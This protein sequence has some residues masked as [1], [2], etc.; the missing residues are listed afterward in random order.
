MPSPAFACPNCD[1]IVLRAGCI[2]QL[3]VHPQFI[4]LWGPWKLW[5]Q[6]NGS[7]G[8]IDWEALCMNFEN[9]RRIVPEAMRRL[10]GILRASAHYPP[11]RSTRLSAR[12][13]HPGRRSRA[14]PLPWIAWSQAP[15][16]RAPTPAARSCSTAPPQR[17]GKRQKQRTIKIVAE[18]EQIKQQ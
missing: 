18:R 12:P 15:R 2:K 13:R 4:I 16:Q 11:P 8:S 5:F 7:L 14:H 1:C 17:H 3:Y 10:P 9:D 6:I